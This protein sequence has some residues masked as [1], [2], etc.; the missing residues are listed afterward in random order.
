ME[1]LKFEF[2][3]PVKGFVKILNRLYPEKNKSIPVDIEAKQCLMIPYDELPE[4]KCK[5]RVEWEYDG[6]DYSYERSLLIKKGHDKQ[7]LT[8]ARLPAMN[9]AVKKPHPSSTL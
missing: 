1:N 3:H 2:C 4:G 6:R 5:V 7:V 9:S 8:V